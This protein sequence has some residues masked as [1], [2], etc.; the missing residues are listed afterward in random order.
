MALVSKNYKKLRDPGECLCV[1]LEEA[2]VCNYH[3]KVLMLRRRRR[4]SR[5]ALYKPFAVSN[6]HSDV[7]APK[8]DGS[9]DIVLKYVCARF[10]ADMI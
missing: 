8:T 1:V 6:S 5:S 2:G 9:F 10:I 4:S 3:I 7:A